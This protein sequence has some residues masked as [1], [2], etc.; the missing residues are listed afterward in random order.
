VHPARSPTPRTHAPPLPGCHAR[1]PTC[2]QLPRQLLPVR[3]LVAQLLAQLPEPRLHL[4]LLPAQ[5]V[6]LLSVLRRPGR[7]ERAVGR[8]KRA[9]MWSRGGCG[10]WRRA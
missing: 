5:L 2:R 1:P 4:R 9:C 6:T 7:G 8:W 10:R 3:P